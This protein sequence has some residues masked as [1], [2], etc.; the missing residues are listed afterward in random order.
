MEGLLSTGPTPSSSRTAQSPILRKAQS[1]ISRTAQGHASKTSQS[2]MYYQHKEKIKTTIQY[3]I[4][5]HYRVIILEN[6][7]A[8]FKEQVIFE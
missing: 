3:Q 4:V 7:S 5:G 6:P 1:H 2:R 8:I